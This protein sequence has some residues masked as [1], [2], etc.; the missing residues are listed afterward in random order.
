MLIAA[1]GLS[2]LCCSGAQELYVPQSA[3][4]LRS[5]I[6]SV[7]P[8][9]DGLG[10]EIEQRTNGTVVGVR[11]AISDSRTVAGHSPLLAARVQLTAQNEVTS[12]DA[13]GPFLSDAENDAL[14]RDV[15]QAVTDEARRRNGMSP[16]RP[17]D[18]KQP[19]GGWPPKAPKG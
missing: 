4:N 12:F 11:V 6:A 3:L 13:R 14:A 19:K 15:R 1:I 8:D 5:F 18:G 9:L 2:V 7:Y 10:I 17:P 16:R